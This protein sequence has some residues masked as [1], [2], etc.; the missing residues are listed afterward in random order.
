[1]GLSWDV[2]VDGISIWLL[3]LTRRDLPA[4]DRRR[5]LAPARAPARLPGA[6]A[7]GRDRPA[8]PVRRRP[9]GAVLRLLGGDAHPVLLPD[10]DVGRRGPRPGDHCA[11]VIYTM[12]GSLLMLVA[13]LATAFIARD[14]T[15]QFTFVIR[16]LVGVQFTDTQ[17]TWLFAGL[18]PGLRDQAA[19][20]ARSTA[21]CPAPTGRRRSW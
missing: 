5:L 18:R 11:F 9:P 17:S 1:M 7:A 6:A 10:R 3:A 2:G 21:G 16:D 15:G 19:A 20:V 4:G 13:I 14:I 8:G 12:V